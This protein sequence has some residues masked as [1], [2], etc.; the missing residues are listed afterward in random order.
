[1]DFDDKVV[2]TATDSSVIAAATNPLL[3]GRRDPG[4][5]RNLSVNGRLDEA[6]IWN[7]SLSDAD[8]TKLWNGGHGTPANQFSAV[9]EP[10]GVLLLA[11]GLGVVGASWIGRKRFGAVS[12]MRQTLA[13]W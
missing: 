6:A 10:G 3:I 9:P 12:T 1:M 2:A 4:D 11:L 13:R 8:V 7:Y 5:S